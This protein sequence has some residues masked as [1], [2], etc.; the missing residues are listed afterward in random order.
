MSMGVGDEDRSESG[1]VRAYHHGQLHD[2]LLEAGL[3]LARQGGPDALVVRELSRRVGVSHNAAYRHFPDR[4]ALLAAVAARCMA[5]FAVLI[6][7][8]V[9]AVPPDGDQVA[10]AMAR[11]R[12]CGQAYLEF[13][14]TE[15]GLFHTAFS[16]PTPYT[17]QIWHTGVGESGLTPYEL[18]GV[19]L[20]ELV[21]VGA[22]PA[23]RRPGAELSA[24]SAVHGYATLLLDGPLRG[25]SPDDRTRGMDQLLATV[26]RG[27]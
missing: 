25:M 6:E 9:G 26:H 20:D 8:R 17:E 3:D 19:R 4:D 22:L 14:L 23:E 2:A 24:W 7:R 18:L 1:D 21:A 11:L 16:P 27:L 13:A 10:L 15:P 12:A 5:L